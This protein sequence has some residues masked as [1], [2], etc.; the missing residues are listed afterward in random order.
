MTREEQIKAI[1]EKIADKTLSEWCLYLYENKTHTVRFQ[2]TL[3]HN[4]LLEIK[5]W[6]IKIIWHPVM[7]WDVLDYIDRN[8]FRNPSKYEW[9]FEIDIKAREKCITSLYNY[10]IWNYKKPIEKLDD[11][12]IEFIYNLIKDNE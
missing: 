6:R 2:E 3:E 9:V 4:F 7:I 12:A 8:L 5:Q 11:N 10:F 1:Y